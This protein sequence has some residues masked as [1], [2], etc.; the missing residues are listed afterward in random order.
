MCHLDETYF[1]DCQ[2]FGPRKIHSPCAIGMQPGFTITGCWH[3]IVTGCCR[4]YSLCPSCR[5]RETTRVLEESIR[6]ASSREQDSNLI[7]TGQ[8]DNSINKSPTEG[9]VAHWI[10]GKDGEKEQKDLEKEA[11]IIE[12]IKKE[13]QREIEEENEGEKQK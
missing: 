5:W 8:G 4:V 9:F 13:I 1:V 7:L 10:H 2:H 11:E 12:K 3:A 6:V